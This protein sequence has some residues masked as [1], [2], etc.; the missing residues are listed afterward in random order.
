MSSVVTATYASTIDVAVADTTA[1]YVTGVLS[2]LEYM[3]VAVAEATITAPATSGIDQIYTVT[4]GTGSEITMADTDVLDLKATT[5][6]TQGAWD[7]VVI[8]LTVTAT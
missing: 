5:G 1:S 3:K 2:T 4:Y 8:T 7:D 6:A